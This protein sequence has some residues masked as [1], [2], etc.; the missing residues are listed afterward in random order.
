M[1]QDIGTGRYRNEFREAKA[2]ADSRVICCRRREILLSLKQKEEKDESTG[3]VCVQQEITFLLY[4]QVIRQFPELSGKETYLFSVDGI[5]YFLFREEA[6]ELLAERA[7]QIFDEFTW[8]RMEVLRTAGP[9]EAAF[10][11][12]TAMQLAGW[13]ADRRFCPRCGQQMQHSQKERMLQCPSCALTEYPKISPAVIVAVTCGD[14]I[15][16]TKY[17]GRSYAKY[18]LIAGFA[19]IGESIEDTVSREV[20]EEV[21]LKIKNLRYYKSQPWSFSDTLLMGFFAEVD[22]DR[23]IR[24]DETEL[25]VAKWCKREDVPEDDGISLTREMMRIFREN[26]DIL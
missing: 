3:A 19:E 26:A 10:A 5:S 18:A 1:I 20:M 9:Q 24:L 15:L 2:E 7:E 14:E 11:A 8:V 6:G 21:G 4:G 23:T 12:V 22:G 13:Y 25:S 17:A 16:L